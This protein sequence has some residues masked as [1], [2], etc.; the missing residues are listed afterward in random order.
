MKYVW[1]VLCK[2]L[3]KH[4][5][6][7]FKVIVHQ[8]NVNTSITGNWLHKIHCFLFYAFSTQQIILLFSEHYNLQINFCG[9]S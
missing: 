2:E 8:L 3:Q 9:T 6:D 1:Y 4:K 7:V 5:S